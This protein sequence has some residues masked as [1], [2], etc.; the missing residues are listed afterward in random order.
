M[1]WAKSVIHSGTAESCTSPNVKAAPKK[2]GIS[3]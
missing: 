1:S 3:R 2:I